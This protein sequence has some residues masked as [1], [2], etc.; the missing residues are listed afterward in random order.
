MIEADDEEDEEES[1]EEE[2]ESG[3]YSSDYYAKSCVSLQNSNA[4]SYSDWYIID[5]KEEARLK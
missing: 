1:F 2:L 3:M 4:T 5:E